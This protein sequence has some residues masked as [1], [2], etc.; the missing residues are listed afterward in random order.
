[1]A[2]QPQDN[3]FV[4]V[5]VVG[6]CQGYTVFVLDVELSNSASGKPLDFQRRL[7]TLFNLLLFDASGMQFP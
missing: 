7:Q 1:M 3:E 4:L 6:A 5:I 2:T